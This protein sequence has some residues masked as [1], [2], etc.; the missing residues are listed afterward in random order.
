MISEDEAHSV[1]S[2]AISHALYTPDSPYPH[3]LISRGHLLDSMGISMRSPDSKGKARARTQLLPEE[4]LFMLERGSLQIWMGREE[5]SEDGTAAVGTWSEEECGVVGA[6][7][8]SVSEGFAAF[9]GKD[10]LTW[11]KYQVRH[12]QILE[13]CRADVQAY[14]YLKR[15]GYTVQRTRR[16]LPEHFKSGTAAMST[17]NSSLPPF[18]TWWF[19]IP[20]FFSGLIRS[21]SISVAQ[22]WR[23]VRLNPDLIMLSGWRG[24]DYRKFC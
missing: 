22:L 5:D 23:R 17:H 14:A 1:C 8:M 3:L 2:K 24:I 19:S 20:T 13:F 12:F 11:E 10:G 7:E 21:I 4:A 16:F 18:R 6:V 15:L 9:L